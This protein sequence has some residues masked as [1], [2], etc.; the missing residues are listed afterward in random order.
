MNTPA[1]AS[2]GATG[3]TTPPD[4]LKAKEDGTATADRFLKLLVAQMQNQDPLNPMDNAQVT[5]QMAQINTVNGIEKLNGTMQA[6]SSQIVQSQMLQGA[7]LVG[8][9]VVVPGNQMS[10]DDANVGEGAFEIGSSADSVQVEVLDSLGRVKDTIDLGKLEAGTH[11]FD[12]PSD[13]A[14]ADAGATFRITAKLASGTPV[15]ATALMRDRVNSVSAQGD[16]MTLDLENSGRT[17]YADI[18]ELN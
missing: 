9:D 13:A 16:S 3:G 2:L 18:R 11:S 12:W 14:T 1:I 4:A 17:P 6:M 15:P 5:S 8:H 7:S 10:F